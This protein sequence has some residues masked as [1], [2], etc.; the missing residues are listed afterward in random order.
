MHRGWLRL[1]ALRLTVAAAALAGV[2]SGCTAD[3][4]PPPDVTPVQETAVPP[5]E[6]DLPNDA[7]VAVDELGPGFNPHRLADLSPVTTMVGGLVLPSVFTPL[8]G[9][10]W[11]RDTSVTTSATVTGNAPFT[12]TYRLRDD[13]QWSDGAPVAAEDF[14]WLWEQMTTQPGVVD[15]A[16]YGLIESVDSADGGKTVDVVFSQRYPAWRELFTG[17]LPS[18][19]L[20]DSPGGFTSGMDAGIPVSAGRFSVVAVDRDR[21]EVELARNDRFW[22]T[23]A[24]LDGLLLRRDGT[25]GQLAESLRNND[26]QLAQVHADLGTRA[27]VGVVPDVRTVEV[28][29]AAV[30]QVALDTTDPRLADPRVRRGLL[31]LLDADVLTTVGSG[32]AP[33]AVL[34]ARAQLL[35]PSQPGYADTA[36]QALTAAEAARLLTDA[37][38]RQ[39][40]GVWQRGGLPLTVVLGADVADLVGTSVAQAAADQLTAAG[41]DAGV[42]LL[43]S[44]ELYGQALA[45]GDVDAVVGRAAVGH[46]LATTLAS[47]FGCSPQV[48]LTGSS[49]PIEASGAAV[50]PAAE[51][52]AS[53]GGNV[54]ALCDVELERLIGQV[55]GGGVDPAAFGVVEA[56]L[57]ELAAVLPLYQDQTLLAVRPELTGVGGAGPLLAGPAGDAA[58][59][60][61]S[62]R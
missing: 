29:Q 52:E 34:R 58:S 15:P 23:P 33:E 4:P 28:P 10:G 40:S 5:P 21:G 57:W 1:S 2:A 45:D 7:V 41:V 54:T 50:P 19:L 60:G 44:D 31:G 59:W 56:R 62:D 22:G 3:P 55:L 9:G 38:Y 17:L 43:T 13:A 8:A 49:T 39:V 24:E 51:P 36:P 16:G 11:T 30:L 18:H 47:R 26:T 53:R 6:Q 27:Q 37:G 25:A 61:R 35:A 46:D 20:R 42:S 32:S 48:E 14:S 12:V